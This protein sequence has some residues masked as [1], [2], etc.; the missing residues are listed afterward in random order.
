MD[1]AQC[2]FLRFLY[3]FEFDTSR[4]AEIQEDVAA[5]EWTSGGGRKLT[6][7]EKHA[8]PDQDFFPH[9]ADFFNPDQGNKAMGRAWRLCSGAVESREGIGRKERWFLSVDRRPPIEF[10][11]GWIYLYLFGT[12]IGFVVID[13]KP[14]STDPEDWFNFVHFFRE[15]DGHRDKTRIGAQLHENPAAPHFAGVAGGIVSH[16]DGKGTYQEI[17]EALLTIIPRRRD[18]WWRDAF[19]PGLLLPWAVLF[20]DH[21]PVEEIPHIMYRARNFFHWK[22]EIHP[23]E[24][25]RRLSDPSLMPYADNQWF[26]FSLGGAGFVALDASPAPFFRI[27]LPDHL[28]GIYF[29]LYVL[30]LHQRLTLAKLSNQVAHCCPDFDELSAEH[31]RTFK[32]IRNAFL[33]FAARGYFTQVTQHEHH[34]RFYAAC[35]KAMELDQLYREVSDE[36]RD[37]Y[38]AVLL[39]ASEKQQESSRELEQFVS[40]WTMRIGVIALLLSFLGVNLSGYTTQQDGIPW[41]HALSIVVLGFSV[42]VVLQ[43]WFRRRK[44]RLD[45]SLNAG[46]ALASYANQPKAPVTKAAAG[47]N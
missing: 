24:N 46:A 8:F 28:G 12:G 33:R 7:W 35:Q 17:I 42:C 27:T 22:Q 15:I 47:E 2:S 26:T 10:T 19:V 9:I 3:P 41:W 39:D 1:V 45:R 37:F 31:V 25:D 11:I 14:H 36:V 40:T 6:L 16:A 21:A 29:M 4:F 34:H 13:A 32:S 44:T 20:L 30:V 38:N 43:R 23:T 5:L 18:R